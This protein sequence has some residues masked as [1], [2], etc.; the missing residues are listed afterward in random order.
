MDSKVINKI[1]KI[2]SNAKFKK[3]RQDIWSLFFKL[4]LYFAQ[5]L[6]N[7]AKMSQTYAYY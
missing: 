3:Y 4:P 6:Q 5:M 2:I 7:V 1:D